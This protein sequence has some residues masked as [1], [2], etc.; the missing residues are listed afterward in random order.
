MEIAKSCSSGSKLVKKLEQP[1]VGCC[2]IIEMFLDKLRKLDTKAN[3]TD[4]SG[5]CYWIYHW[6]IN[7]TETNS[8]NSK[9]TPLE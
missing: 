5:P 4:D 8:G 1:P 6:K 7:G 9:T 2:D 3:N